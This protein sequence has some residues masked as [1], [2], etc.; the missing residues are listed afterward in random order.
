MASFRTHVT[1][2]I[3]LGATSVF[4]LLSFALAPA[5][6]SF[7]M[8]VA[9]FVAI[10]SILPDMDS[11]SGVPFHVTFGSLSLVAGGLAFLYA[12]NMS[13][14][15]WTTVYCVFG[16]MIVVWGI[17]GSLFRRFTRHRGMAHSIP[18]AML[19]GLLVFSLSIRLDFDEWKSFLLGVAIV[20][21]Y[22]SHL[23]LDEIYAAINFHGMLFIPNK[24]FGSALKF[25]SQDRGINVVVYGLILFLFIGNGR[26]VF[27]LG[28]KLF[29]MIR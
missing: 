3:A 19:A 12:R 18:A 16:A 21:G 24:A 7:F 11:D 17:V 22:V 1:V 25:F 20:M 26:E 9:L 27:R 5:S 4:F 13:S 2:G 29:H 28:E 14:D 10:G 23:I 8:L 6:W 15:M